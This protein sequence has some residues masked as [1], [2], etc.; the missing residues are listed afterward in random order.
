MGHKVPGDGDGLTYLLVQ[1]SSNSS[2]PED[3]DESENAGVERSDVKFCTM[4]CE[5][6]RWPKKNV[7]GARSCRTFNAIWCEALGQHTTR[8]APCT[9]EFGARRPKPNW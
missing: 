9:V 4:E 1:R 3:R 2:V 5:Y 8:N 6:A 7:D